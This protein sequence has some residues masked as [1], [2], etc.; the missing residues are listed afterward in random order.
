[1]FPVWLVCDFKDISAQP[2]QS[3]CEHTP[4]ALQL[5]TISRSIAHFRAMTAFGLFFKAKLLTEGNRM[6]FVAIFF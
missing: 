4:S 5:Y 3:V 2:S 1:M 6:V